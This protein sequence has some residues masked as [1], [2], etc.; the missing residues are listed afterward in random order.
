VSWRT[1]SRKLRPAAEA[2]SDK[3]A[4]A[5][6][7]AAKGFRVFPLVEGGKLPAIQG[8]PTKATSDEAQVKRWFGPDPNTGW[9]PDHNIG[10]ATGNGLVVLD[11]DCKNGARGF[12]SLAALEAVHGELPDTFTV[13]TPSGGRHAYFSTTRDLRNSAS[14]LAEGID[15][16]GVGGFVVGPGSTIGGQ[17]YVAV[18]GDHP[19]APVPAICE[20][21]PPRPLREEPGTARNQASRIE[22]DHPDAVARAAEFLKSAEPA[23][24]GAGGDHH[25]FATAAKCKDFGVSQQT[26]L[27]LMLAHWNERC[28]PPWNPDDLQHKIQNA[29]DYGHSPP[30]ISSPQMDFE[31]I[32]IQDSKRGLYLELAKDVSPDTQS[33][34]LIDGYLDQHAFSVIYGDSNTGKTFVALDIAFHI[35]AGRQWAGAEVAQGGV[36]YVAAEG[37]KGIRKRIAALRKHFTTP[38]PPI[39]IIPCAVNLLNSAAD[40]KALAALIDR[41][42]LLLE[43]PIVLIVIDTLARAMAGGNENASDDMGAFVTNIDRIRAASGAHAMVVHHSGKDQAKGARGHSSLRAATDTELEVADWCVSVRKQRDGDYAAQ[44]TFRLVEV[45]VGE[46]S[47]GKPIA[48]CV[49]EWGAAAEFEDVPLTRD[50][51]NYLMALKAAR[52]RLGKLASAGIPTEAVVD[53]YADLGLPSPSE[54][55]VRRGLVTLESKGAVKRSGNGRWVKWDVV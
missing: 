24:E 25:T 50:E 12:E 6:A 30:G 41:A 22:L 37:G 5:L 36:V 20:K 10:V 51:Q 14:A 19:I 7:L 11:V 53:A 39:A 4:H 47:R 17:E 9:T 38:A 46:T 31:P 29:Y 28:A 18:A 40:V 27:E 44:K 16:R 21:I 2:L 54:R 15:I 49:V 35:A 3:L 43:Q 8:W 23:V 13:N 45:H 26:A 33:E 1:A 55:T 42:A 48:S 52:D 32:I 34:P